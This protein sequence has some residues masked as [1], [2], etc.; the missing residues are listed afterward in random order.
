MYPLFETIKCNK[1][2]LFNL[3]FHQ[4]RFDNARESYYGITEKIN[5]KDI[6][7]IPACAINGLFRCKIIYTN[8]IKKIEF[9]PH[10]YREITS[11]KLVEDNEIDYRFKYSNRQRI[12]KLFELRENAD[13]I[14]IVKNGLITDS[15]A[16]NSVFFDGQKWWTPKSPLLPG[17]QRARLIEEGKIFV[18]DIYPED[19]SKYEKAGLINALNDLQEM[20]TIFTQNIY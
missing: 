12:Q 17:T 9:I 20:P 5:L 11:L 4:A 19:I 7:E 14:L 15:S 8:K 10:Q 18:C 13:D 16:A 3:R 6:I 1:G 2:K